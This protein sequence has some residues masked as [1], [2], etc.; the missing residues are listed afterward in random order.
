MSNPES[1]LP[2]SDCQ[3]LDF[4]K[5]PPAKCNYKLCSEPLACVKDEESYKCVPCEKKRRKKKFCNFQIKASLIMSLLKTLSLFSLSAFTVA[6]WVQLDTST[7]IHTPFGYSSP[8]EP[9]E[10]MFYLMK[11]YVEFVIDDIVK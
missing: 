7:T 1:L 11:D 5:R 9:D 6:M 8:S 4:P 2:S 10:I 3:Y